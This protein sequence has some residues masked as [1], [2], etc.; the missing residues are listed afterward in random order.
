M[1]CRAGARSCIDGHFGECEDEV[2]PVAEGCNGLDDDCDGR[3]DEQLTT[4]DCQ[5]ENGK[6]ECS[7]GLQVCS[8]GE[9][10]CLQVTGPQ[11]EMCNDRDDD[12]DGET[13]EATALDCYEAGCTQDS[14]GMYTC[15][16]ACHGGTRA[17][18]HGEYAACSGTVTPAPM[19]SCTQS[20]E[21]SA[22]EDC[23]GQFDEGCACSD[24]TTCYTGAPDTKTRAPCHAGT[25]MCADSTHGTC[26]GEVTPKLETCANT[27]VDDDCD[28]EM[29]NIPLD[30]TSCTQRSAGNGICKAGALWKCVSGEQK[31]VDAP[32]EAE[33]CD[34]RNVDEDCD[35]KID[36]GFNLA[37]DSNN[38]GACGLTCGAG[39][40]CCAGHCVNTTTSN[41]HCMSCGN[42]C[43][44]NT[45]CSSSC[46]DR[47]KDPNNCG[48][49]GNV[50]SGLLKG[51]TNGKCTK[52]L[53]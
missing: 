41:D 25:Q 13:D 5:V 2:L 50:C 46:V 26:V 43:N 6:G 37:T 40:L 31:C 35:G 30:G 28:G 17:C 7:L 48:T 16:G 44:G 19:D 18:E 39:L 33:R 12:C 27:G 11:S 36:E 21:T 51:C 34:G 22:D 47:N 14:D 24:G 45:C 10:R 9:T 23:D 32:K 49:C 4:S 42:S 3:V 15:V 53:L 20:G 38:C 1:P 29:D 52:L 8:H